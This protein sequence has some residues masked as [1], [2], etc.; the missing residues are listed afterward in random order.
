MVTCTAIDLSEDEEDKKQEEDD[1]SDQDL[2]STLSFSAPE[3]LLRPPNA[4]PLRIFVCF[5]SHLS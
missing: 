1:G 2:V 4:H 3:A 5:L